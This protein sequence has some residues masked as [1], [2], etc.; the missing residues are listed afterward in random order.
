M[1]DVNQEKVYNTELQTGKI[2]ELIGRLSA[3]D[4]DKSNLRSN[5]TDGTKKYIIVPG[6]LRDIVKEYWGK[7]VS[8]KGNIVNQ[9]TVNLL[10]IDAA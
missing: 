9:S 7:T 10:H 4:E 2:I 3:A 8:I 5:V 6:G 1:P